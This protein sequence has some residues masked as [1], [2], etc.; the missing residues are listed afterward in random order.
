MLDGLC[1][2]RHK[3]VIG[4][5][6]EN[7][8]A[9]TDWDMQIIADIERSI[10]R[11]E[12]AIEGKCNNEYV[13]LPIGDASPILVGSHRTNIQCKLREIEAIRRG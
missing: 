3:R 1:G 8:M 2:N 11:I 5:G 12:K 13:R 7:I 6:R 4:N 10:A 9:L